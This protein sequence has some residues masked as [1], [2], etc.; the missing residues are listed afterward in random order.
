MKRNPSTLTQLLIDRGHSHGDRPAFT[1]LLGDEQ[2]SIQWT[3]ASLAA[4][5]RTIAAK[6]QLEG[7]A[8]ER[9]LLLYPPGLDFIAGFCGCVFAGAIAVP[10]YPPRSNRNAARLK[11]IIEDCQP[12]AV[13]TTRETFDRTK[14]LIAADGTLAGLKFLTTDDLA[15]DIAGGWRQPELDKDS[16]AFLQ[17]TSGSTATPKGVIVS[18]GNILHNQRSIQEAFRQSENSVIAGWLPLYHDM[19]LIGN[20]LQPLYL[21]A[22]CI[23]MS[24]VSFLQKPARWLEAISKYKATTSGG[25]DFAYELCVRKITEEQQATLDLSS[26]SVAFNGA[27]PVRARTL[28]RFA[29][30]FSCNGFRKT[31]FCPCYGLAE[32]TLLVSGH[33]ADDAPLELNVD[34]GALGQHTIRTDA[35]TAGTKPVVSC[36]TLAQENRVAIINP[37]SLAKCSSTQV[38]EIWITGPS[39]AQG[40]WDR[41]EETEKTFRARIPGGDGETFLRTGDLGFLHNGELFVTGRA[42][43][44]LII[45]GRNYYPQDIE[46]TAS[47]AHPALQAG[48]AAAFSI[49]V[50][51]EEQLAIVHEVR[52]GNS[53]ALNPLLDSICKAVVEQYEIQPHTVALVPVGRIPKTSSGKIQR[54]ACRELLVAQGLQ[55]ILEWNWRTSEMGGRD[56]LAEP[57]Q[58]DSAAGIKTWLIE[59]L[60]A[61]A[62]VSREAIDPSYSAARY[63]LDSLGAIELGYAVE[64]E[65]GIRSSLPDLLGAASLHDLAQQLLEKARAGATGSEGSTESTALVRN[66]PEAFPLT[67]GQRSLWFLHQLSPDSTAYHL[68]F[69][70]RVPTGLDAAAFR[71]SL[72]TL[73]DRHPLLRTTFYSLAGEPKQRVRASA[74]ACFEEVDASDWSES[75][76][77]ARLEEQA[78]V[79]FCLEEGPLFRVTLFRPRRDEY[80]LALTVH[81]IIA[82]LWSLSL[83]MNEL[84]LTYRAE[85]RGEALALAA[86]AFE[87]RD[88]V[89]WER[90]LLSSAEGEDLYAYWSSKLAGELANLD[91]QTDR[92]RGSTQTFKGASQQFELSPELTRKLKLLA[93]TSNATVY[94]ILLTAYQALLHRYTGQRDIIVGSPTAGRHRPE[95][96]PVCGYF[97]NS[98][99]V[100]SN[101]I[102]TETFS[103]LLAQV[104]ATALDA[105]RHERYPFFSLVERLQPARDHRRSPIFQTM[106]ALEKTFFLERE[107]ISAFALGDS[108]AAVEFNG[109]PLEP[110]ALNSGAALFDLMLVMADGSDSLRGFLQY[111]SDLF[112]AQRIEQMTQHYVRVLEQIGADAE[113]RLH[114]LK[115]L[116]EDERSSLAA[117]WKRTDSERK[118]YVLD[119]HMQPVPAGVVGE[120]Y[121]RVNQSELKT[122]QT[123]DN[124]FSAQGEG[125]LYR[126]EQRVRYSPQ[127]ELDFLTESRAARPKEQA[128]RTEWRGPATPEQEK[129][130]QIFAEVLAVDRVGIDDDFFALGGHSLLATQI[131]SRVRAEFEI[132]FPLRA[133]F[134]SPTVAALADRV[135]KELLKGSEKT[136]LPSIMPVSRDLPL[137]LSF[138]QQR[139]WFLDQL[140]PGSSAYNMAAAVSFRG[141][142]NAEILARS[143]TEIVRRHEV[144]RTSF[145]VENGNPVQ[146]IEEPGP[147]DIPIIDVS[148]VAAPKQAAQQLAREEAERPF[149]LSRGPLI[150]A[151]LVRVA[152]EEHLLL[153]TLHHSVCDGWSVN[154][155]IREFTALYSSFSASEP[156]PLEKLPIQY[157]DFA[158]WQRQWLRGDILNEHVSYWRRKLEGVSPLRL[159]VAKGSSDFRS[160]SGRND[161]FDLPPATVGAL[162]DL[163][164]AE[165]TTLFMTL[166]A[167]F[168]VLLHRQSGQTEFAVGIHLAGRPMLEVEKLIGFFV[169]MLPLKAELGGDPTFKELLERVRAN[170]LEA[171]T[172]Q[173]L[174]LEKLVEELK[175]PRVNG[176]PQ[177]FQATFA[178]QNDTLAIHLPALE[179]EVRDSGD[180]VARLGLVLWIVRSSNGW[181]AC[182]RYN[183][184]V[185]DPLEILELQKDF[186]TL[187]E[188][189]AAQPSARVSELAAPAERK[190]SKKAFH[191]ES[192][193]RSEKAVFNTRERRPVQLTR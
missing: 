89:E 188:A 66:K 172:Y 149:D 24:P 170:S 74:Q 95:W 38:G 43:D 129:L 72:Q 184:E 119:D 139:L 64:Q 62:G 3:Y 161:S 18:H 117:M 137:P 164:Q 159:R 45:R 112:D 2:R 109:L 81:H 120:L 65:L 48:A 25:P 156:S 158:H 52:G 173:A 71:R 162:Q 76:L 176:R 111:N 13:L 130:C 191:A 189:I 121:V 33:S 35:G 29:K 19:G 108:G 118:W 193:T 93:G 73:V 83:L 102:G 22:Q 32:A 155:L 181:S 146:R 49:E 126:T 53:E 79:P 8:G 104:R 96:A 154:I 165:G 128:S 56:V 28:E 9:V 142:L 143:L 51:G 7:C 97:V 178:M 54:Y 16:V 44:L 4:N 17:Y 46:A 31:A 113:I 12:A 110:R 57:S 171:Q 5:A 20:V 135:Q 58:A 107:G 133:L 177:M 114:D 69:A 151:K 148:C 80:F 14:G 122:T 150:R 183:T 190:G 185:F 6:L 63:G 101:L 84:T 82:D 11:A 30:R 147:L 99:V 42:K 10:A 47:A 163:S 141:R 168:E 40:Y 145:Q 125:K 157:A 15:P 59:K 60:A 100:R 186:A 88:Y 132:K 116:S 50:D 87:Y 94:M 41:P 92:P 167:A 105:F 98:V 61:R 23:L 169:N 174:P 160:G 166:L 90:N 106:F 136:T 70:A 27:E 153:L 68:A 26:W 115:L 91:L 140:E 180:E 187:L 75:Q 152:P 103:E 55:S 34:A 144:L 127:G 77:T 36:G 131:V 85:M 21:G 123:V 124:P 179:G 175:P 86:P 67:Q 1:F 39:V 182:W 37:E 134:E 192:F 138:A 78:R